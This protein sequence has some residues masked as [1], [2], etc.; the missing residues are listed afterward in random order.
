MQSLERPYRRPL[1]GDDDSSR[2]SHE[3]PRFSFEGDDRPLIST[4]LLFHQ[5]FEDEEIAHSPSFR[6]I[7]NALKLEQDIIVG[8]YHA[9]LYDINA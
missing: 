5:W 4:E 3:L 7:G 6:A 9:F 1:V 8:A 2:N